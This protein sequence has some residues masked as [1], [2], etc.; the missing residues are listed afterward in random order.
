MDTKTLQQ[1]QKQAEEVL[2]QLGVDAKVVSEVDASQVV[3]IE[4]LPQ[5]EDESLGIL[6]GYRGETL[7][8]L[9]LILSFMINKGREEWLPV[10]VD[11]DGY[12]VRHEEKLKL[13]AQRL[14]EKAF[15][16]NE[17]IPLDPMP[18]ADRRIIH[19]T[20]SEDEKVESESVGEGWERYVVI[21]PKGK[22]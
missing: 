3:K 10:F 1:F 8:A 7:R 13:L 20:L 18:A 11:V 2:V 15:Y 4:I 22:K 6:I 5:R 9:Q 14:A 12:R 19:L 17:P 21:K 16:L